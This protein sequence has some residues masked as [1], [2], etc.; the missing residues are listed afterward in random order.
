[1]KK[2]GAFL[3]GLLLIAVASASGAQAQPPSRLPR[4]TNPRGLFISIAPAFSKLDYDADSQQY[5]IASGITATRRVG[6]Q[7]GIGYQIPLGRPLGQNFSF[8]PA[9]L[10]SSAGEKLTAVT[11]EGDRVFAGLMVPLDFMLN[12]HG[13][14]ITL[15]P[16]FGYLTSTK[17]VLD[18]GTSEELTGI[19]LFHYGISAGAGFEIKLKTMALMIKAG[20]QIGL[21]NF[22]QTET[23]TASSFAKHNAFTAGIALR[24]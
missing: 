11:G 5:L 10:Y 14:F 15:G 2:R 18:D 6:Y 24:I 22:A 17:I 12:F 4:P 19:N 13:P 8:L 20:Y 7:V 16:Y 21:S 23:A 1:M 3:I 9:V